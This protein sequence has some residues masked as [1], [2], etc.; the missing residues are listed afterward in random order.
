MNLTP[1]ETQL[2]DALL[3]L[4]RPTV[5]AAIAEMTGDNRAALE[6]DA[7]LTLAK[8]EVWKMHEAGDFNVLH[9][10]DAAIGAFVGAVLLIAETQEIDANQLLDSLL[11]EDHI[12]E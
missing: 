10:L 12:D 1:E 8:L 3:M 11:T 5:S 7:M 2:R 6:A 4:T 9:L